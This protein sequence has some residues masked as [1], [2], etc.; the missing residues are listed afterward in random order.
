M[1]VRETH[2]CDRQAQV[3]SSY[4]LDFISLLLSKSTPRQAE[5]SMS[6]FLKQQVPMGSLGAEI[7]QLPNTAESTKA[8]DKMI[9]TGWKLQSLNAAADSLLQSATRLEKEMEQ[10]ATY[11][12]QVLAVKERGWS[13]SRLP[14]EKHTLSVRYGFAEG[15]TI[16][17]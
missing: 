14:R 17:S 7:V 10:E 11:W 9:S 12:E 5:L 13:L 2:N 15:M 16:S 6:T 4:A 8:N 1:L 3:Q